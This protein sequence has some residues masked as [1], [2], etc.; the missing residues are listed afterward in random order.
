MWFESIFWQSDRPVGE[1]PGG[2]GGDECQGSVF[3]LHGGGV[4]LGHVCRLLYSM[5]LVE[6]KNKLINIINNEKIKRPRP[7]YAH[8]F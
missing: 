2:A 4:N 1:A 6:I 5:N 3:Y 8:F 7:Q